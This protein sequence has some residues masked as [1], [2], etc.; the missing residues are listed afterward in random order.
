M[1]LDV[2]SIHEILFIKTRYVTTYY[3]ISKKIVQEL[4]LMP[5]NI[6]EIMFISRSNLFK[7]W[8]VVLDHLLNVL[9]I[10]YKDLVDHEAEIKDLLRQCDNTLESIPPSK[11]KQDLQ[12]K[13]EEIRAEYDE[14]KLCALE[15]DQKLEASMRHAQCFQDM[16]DKQLLWL[17]F[18]QD[19]LEGF[20]PTELQRD[21]IAK[22]LSD[23][24]V[25]RSNI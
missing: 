20:Q 9:Q 11:E 17:Q 21:I 2:E 13:A 24:Q 4:T 15:R 1:A 22:K 14:L 23:A 3:S 8:Y 18:S 5:M 25:C 16:L 19:K 7:I 10:L 12:D 6:Y